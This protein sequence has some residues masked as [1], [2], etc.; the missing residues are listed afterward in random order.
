[1]ARCVS[2]GRF[3]AESGP[4]IRIVVHDVGQTCGDNREN[5][6]A[7]RR[8]VGGRL[9]Q[10]HLGC[11]VEVT[12]TREGRH[13]RARL[14]PS[15]PSDVIGV[16]V[17]VDDR[18]NRAGAEPRAAEPVH[19]GPLLLIPEWQLGGLEIA[20]ARI[21]EH[22]TTGVLDDEGLDP[23]GDIAVWVGVVI[24]HPRM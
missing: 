12:R 10:V 8:I 20:D 19:E 21:N 22:G 16:E 1:M 3:E 15:I 5:G 6:F 14:G 23:Q 9:C 24:Q 13:P 18:V 7:V 17:G 11:G 2:W 4:E